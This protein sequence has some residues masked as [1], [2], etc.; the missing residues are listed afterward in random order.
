MEFSFGFASVL[1]VIFFFYRNIRN[2]KPICSQAALKTALN[3]KLNESEW[4]NRSKTPMLL[5]T[6]YYDLIFTN[7]FIF[8]AE[9]A[10]HF[11][12]I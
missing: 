5:S 3:C 11:P 4:M 1:Q 8:L 10:E 2:G 9:M 6:M 12:L 7:V